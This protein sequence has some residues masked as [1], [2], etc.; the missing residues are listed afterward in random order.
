MSVTVFA[1]LQKQYEPLTLVYPNEAGNR[2]IVL[3]LSYNAKGSL[4]SIISALLKE[5]TMNEEV[6]YGASW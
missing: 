6:K 2:C 5:G 4:K 3:V 1:I